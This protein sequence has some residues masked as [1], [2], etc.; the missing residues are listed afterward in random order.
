MISS[1]SS[2]NLSPIQLAFLVKCREYRCNLS[3]SYSKDTFSNT[4]YPQYSSIT[5]HINSNHLLNEYKGYAPYLLFEV[6]YPSLVI[7]TRK[8]IVWYNGKHRQLG[9]CVYQECVFSL[10]SIT[11]Y[12]GINHV[13]MFETSDIIINTV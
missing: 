9:P 13:V 10:R 4:Q 6:I 8:E 12:Y 7:S 1:P 5:K 3:R 2:N 11:L